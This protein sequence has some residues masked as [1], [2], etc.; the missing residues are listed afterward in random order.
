MT[1]QAGRSYP[2]IE[3]IERVELEQRVREKLLVG[4]GEGG[5]RLASYGGRSPRAG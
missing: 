3:R 1:A 2:C 4:R 5:L